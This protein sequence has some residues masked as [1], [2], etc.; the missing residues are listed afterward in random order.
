MKQ[1]VVKN[2]EIFVPY[3]DLKVIFDDATHRVSYPPAS[4]MTTW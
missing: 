4:N 1:L 2:R 3:P